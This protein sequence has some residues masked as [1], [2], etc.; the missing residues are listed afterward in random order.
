IAD[1]GCTVNNRAGSLERSLDDSGV[2]QVPSAY[3]NA[4]AF[5][6]RS[7]TARAGNGANGQA[8]RLA[9]VRNMAAYETG[10][11]SDQAG[12]GHQRTPL[13]VGMPVRAAGR[14]LLSSQCGASSTRGAVRKG[15][16]Q[17]FATARSI[18]L[19]RRDLRQCGQ[20]AWWPAGDLGRSNVS[21]QTGQVQ[22]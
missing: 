2:G 7:I 22:R 11:S 8:A 10:G 16:A 3:G 21:R 15:R 9:C 14:L 20:C 1:L 13:Q 19:S 17:S 12:S 18:P 4:Q 6:E 5:Q